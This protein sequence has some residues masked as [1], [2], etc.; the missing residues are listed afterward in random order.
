MPEDVYPTE[1]LG[2]GLYFVLET[3]AG[4]FLTV[5]PMETF[6]Q[7]AGWGEMVLRDENGIEPQ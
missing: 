1:I 4:F 2:R 6:D 7:A 3:P 5:G